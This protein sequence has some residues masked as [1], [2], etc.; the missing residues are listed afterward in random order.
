MAGV[1][2]AHPWIFAMQQ[3]KRSLYLFHRYEEFFLFEMSQHSL[4][5]V[6]FQM[7]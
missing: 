4:S 7:E 3:A 6:H 5:Q 1:K 2:V